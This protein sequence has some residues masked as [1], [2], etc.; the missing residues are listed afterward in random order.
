MKPSASYWVQ[1]SSHAVKCPTTSGCLMVQVFINQAHE[2]STNLCS[3]NTFVRSPFGQ[4]ANIL[5][6]WWFEPLWKIWTSI[7]MIIPNIWENKKWQ[8][9]HQP[10]MVLNLRLFWL[11][12]S[13]INSSITTS[14]LGCIVQMLTVHISVDSPLCS[15]NHPTLLVPNFA[16]IEITTFVS[17]VSMVSC[18][19]LRDNHPSSGAK[20]RVIWRT[21]WDCLG[22]LTCLKNHEKII[23]IQGCPAAQLHI[24]RSRKVFP[25]AALCATASRWVAAA[26]SRYTKI[27]KHICS[28][29]PCTSGGFLK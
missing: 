15:K 13:F 7:G 24:P 26:T 6:G 3:N 27:K 21:S 8:P 22:F 28:S 14:P 16:G 11:D 17:L 1:I 18:S 2:G 12:Q 19:H 29:Y 5:S 9:N 25:T 23:K 4:S 20:H 10:A